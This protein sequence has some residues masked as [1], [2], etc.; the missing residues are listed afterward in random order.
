MRTCKGWAKWKS[1][2]REEA[3]HIADQH[4]HRTSMA[5]SLGFQGGY[6]K[7]FREDLENL[8]LDT[9]HW[10]LKAEI[11]PEDGRR[12]PRRT[13]KSYSWRTPEK[14]ENLRQKALARTREK[15]EREILPILFVEHCILDS[16]TA[17]RF[18]RRWNKTFHWLEYKCQNCGNDGTWLGKKLCLQ[19]D[20][21]NGRPRDNRLENLR[22]LCP[23][24]HSQTSTWGAGN[25]PENRKK[26]GLPPR[27]ELSKL[28][29]GYHKEIREMIDGSPTT[30]RS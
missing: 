3:Q 19:L 5:K 12:R 15:F 23:N 11:G 30:L 27:L 20:H 6:L 10:N 24:C 29:E 18:I 22:F 26:I 28:P 7:L 2:S 1:L 9:E 16:N 13:A 25:K 14:I 8:N 4:P 17:R 21:V